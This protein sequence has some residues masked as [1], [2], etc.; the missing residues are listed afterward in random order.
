MRLVWSEL[1]DL[2]QFTAVSK[3]NKK[4]K[5]N[6]KNKK[7]GRFLLSFLIDYFIKIESVYPSG[8]FETELT[9]FRQFPA[10]YG[11]KKIIDS[12]RGEHLC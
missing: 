11:A 5:K 7:I 9:S 3:K 8:T 10:I 2:R 6:E 1:A 12:S 4:K